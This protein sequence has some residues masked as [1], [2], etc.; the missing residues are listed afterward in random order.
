MNDSGG[1]KGK[2]DQSIAA[3]SKKMPGT[4]LGKTPD[5]RDPL[6]KSREPARHGTGCRTRRYLLS[7]AVLLT[8]ND[9]AVMR[10]LRRCDGRGDLFRGSLGKTP[11]C[12]ITK[13]MTIFSACREDRL[14]RQRINFWAAAWNV[15]RISN[16]NRRAAGPRIATGPCCAGPERPSRCGRADGPVVASDRRTRP[17]D[18]HGRG[19]PRAN[20]WPGRFGTG[21]GRHPLSADRPGIAL[22]LYARL[23]VSLLRTA[24][25]RTAPWSLEPDVPWW[26]GRADADCPG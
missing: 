26:L 19:K 8:A 1:S 3:L 24:L 23:R 17:R 22:L 13:G 16:G 14:I 21:S 12:P 2:R 25:P 15:H 4:A 11:D 9:N 5:S 7:I 6:D 10:P 18:D 20:L